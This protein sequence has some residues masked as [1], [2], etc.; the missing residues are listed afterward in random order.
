MLSCLFLD[1]NGL[2][3][4]EIEI[5]KGGSGMQLQLSQ[6]ELASH[7]TKVAKKMDEK[8]VEFLCLFSPPLFSL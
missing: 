3:I 2:G 7:R 1:Y 4:T 8:D 6:E 5:R